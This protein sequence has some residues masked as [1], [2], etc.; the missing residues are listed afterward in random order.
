MNNKKV[1]LVNNIEDMK[2]ITKFINQGNI[3]SENS[4]LLKDLE[5]SL[6]LVDVTDIT[7]SSSEN[8]FYNYSLTLNTYWLR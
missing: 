3:S 8:D 6:R 4:E 1:V 7:V 2:I 5:N